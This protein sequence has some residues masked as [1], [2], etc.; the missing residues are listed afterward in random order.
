MRDEHPEP[1]PLV[2][3]QI[4]FPLTKTVLHPSDFILPGLHAGCLCSIVAPGGAGRSCLALEIAL[5]VADPEADIA[6]LGSTR[7]GKVVYIGADDSRDE[8]GPTTR[9]TSWRTGSI[10]WRRGF[11]RTSGRGP[12]ATSK[13]AR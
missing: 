5:A 1:K 12:S 11:R 2:F 3:P 7:G 13:S 8:L 6:R 10:G 9:G 4:E